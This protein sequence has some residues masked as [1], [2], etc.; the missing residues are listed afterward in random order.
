[1]PKY[2]RAILVLRFYV[3]LLV[4]NKLNDTM[5]I[6]LFSSPAVCFSFNYKRTGSS[7]QYFAS[8]TR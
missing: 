7:V 4:K 3:C 5:K 2:E 6:D 1:M 8:V